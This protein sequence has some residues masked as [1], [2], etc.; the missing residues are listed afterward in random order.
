LVLGLKR[1]WDSHD[2]GFGNLL[3]AK[4]RTHDVSRPTRW[5]EASGAGLS[6]GSPFG[7]RR[8]E[9]RKSGGAIQ[10]RDFGP[11]DPWR[12]ESAQPVHAAMTADGI[13]N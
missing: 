2:G 6:A 10:H 8:A 5:R 1:V 9:I 3:V 11:R 12:C 4:W 7:A 13:I